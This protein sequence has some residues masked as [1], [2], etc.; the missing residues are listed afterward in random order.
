M[1]PDGQESALFCVF[2]RL[3]FLVQKLGGTIQRLLS[4]THCSARHASC[5]WLFL[6]CLVFSGCSVIPV[7]VAA[8]LAPPARG[9]FNPFAPRHDRA[10]ND[11]SGNVVAER[12]SRVPAVWY[13]MPA[14]EELPL[15]NGQIIAMDG[16]DPHGF[17]ATMFAV[18][19]Q[20][21]THLGIVAIE[22]DG[23]VVYDV[24]GSLFFLP[25]AS[26]A[27]HGSGRVRRW[28]L[29]EFLESRSSGG[30]FLGIFSP[31]QGVDVDRMLAFVRQH[32]AAETRFDHL[33]DLSDQRALYC[34]EFVALAV[35]A[36]GGDPVVPIPAIDNR[37][38]SVIR[39]YVGITTPSFILPGQLA[40]VRRLVILVTPDMPVRHIDVHFEIRRELHRRFSRDARVGT[41]VGISPLDR[42]MVW[43]ENVA[44]FIRQTLEAFP[45]IEIDVAKIR[46]E[47]RRM[48][49]QFFVSVPASPVAAS[50]P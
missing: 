28:P 13:Q 5:L 9:E 43:R 29:R 42:S 19:Y 1:R 34:S 44:E 33:Y 21:W 8:E 32:H 47:V 7:R 48:A 24:N 37:S 2:R 50:S 49:D 14:L 15:A 38:I 36:G 31:P 17:F 10:S 27:K 4:H 45:K 25:G 16:R 12:P 6:P 39:E 26:P 18:E 22:A 20:P 41:L 3:E 30:Q 35:Q 46:L 23:P 11:R 40:D